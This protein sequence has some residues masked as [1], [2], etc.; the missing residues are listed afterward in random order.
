[1]QD[2]NGG[3]KLDTM[4]RNTLDGDWTHFINP[5]A[6]K[7]FR[8]REGAHITHAPPCPFVSWRMKIEYS[9]LRYRR[10]YNSSVRVFVWMYI[11]AAFRHHIRLALTLSVL[12][13]RVLA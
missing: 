2:V 3:E 13:P 9:P 8:R 10:R 1:M 6:T 4:A 7:W 5:K 12:R 11:N